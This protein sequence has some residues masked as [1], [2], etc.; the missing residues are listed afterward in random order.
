MNNVEQFLRTIFEKF[1]D[2]EAI[3]DGE[4]G[5]TDGFEDILAHD[6][7]ILVT[8]AEI[9]ADATKTHHALNVWQ[10]QKLVDS[11]RN[12]RLKGGTQP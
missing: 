6:A 8:L 2:D 12:E 10:F 3:I 5:P 7:P 9:L 4:W 11:L 1:C